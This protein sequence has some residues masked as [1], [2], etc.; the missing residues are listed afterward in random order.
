VRETPIAGNNPQLIAHSPQLTQFHMKKRC[1]SLLIALFLCNIL[2]GQ[3]LNLYE[4]HWFR[5]A[6]GA[7]PYRLLYPQSFDSTH[8]YP[9]VI[10]LHGAYDR[11]NDNE[12]QLAIGGRFFL[13]Q[14]N[15]DSF[16]SI[17]VFPQCPAV[18]V[19]AYFTTR[20]DSATGIVT[21]WDF[22]FGKKPTWPSGMLIQLIDS[23]SKRSFADPS[24][25]YIGGLSQG[26]MGVFDL[27]ARYPNVF[28]AAFPICG[29]GKVST[30]KFFAGKTAMWIF[31]G[32]KDDVV[33]TRFSRDYF[34]QLQK[35]GSVVRYTEYPG[36]KHNSWVNAFGEKGLMEW[37]WTQH[38]DADK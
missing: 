3:D 6:D 36:V 23:L 35:A 13:R 2:L 5:T 20:V 25:I 1:T 31:H 22:P 33:P 34:K 15:R 9:I 27:V 32:E 16:P 26:G 38:K 18:D 11:G 37:L 14:H 19:W 4:K 10:F 30:A 24:R 17:V 28:A 7:L 12:S 29:A 21:G 8:R